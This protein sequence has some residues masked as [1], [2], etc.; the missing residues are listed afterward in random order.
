[1]FVYVYVYTHKLYFILTCSIQYNIMCV[2]IFIYIQ[3]RRVC[4]PIKHS[5]SMV[6]ESAFGP[7]AVWAGPAGK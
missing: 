4:W 6:I 1:M 7:L 5:N 2:Y 3:V